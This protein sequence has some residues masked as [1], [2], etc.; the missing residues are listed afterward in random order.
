MTLRAFIL[1]LSLCGLSPAAL[2]QPASEEL[3]VGFLPAE[4]VNATLRKTLSPQGRIEWITATGPVRVT[5]EAAKIGAAQGALA[6]LQRAPAVVPI[7]ILFATTERR[8]VQR[9]PVEP[10]VMERGFPVPNRHDPPRII[11]NAPGSFTVVPAQPRDFTTRNVGPGTVVNPSVSGFTTLTPEVRMSETV[12]AQAGPARRFTGSTV[13]GKPV[14]FIAQR[15]APDAAALHALAR[16]LGA[17]A[18]DE[19]AWTAAATGFLVTPTI[20][21]GALV[22]TVVP[23]IFLPA[24][25]PGEPARPVPLTACAA[26][27]MIAR[28]APANTGLL[29]RTDQEFYR[30]FLGMPP[31]AN[32]AFTALTV[33]ADVQ[34]VGAQR[35]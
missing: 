4:W 5:D 2:A 10:P 19:P 28:G 33:T 22:V 13:P 8:V 7:D 23:Q 29:P 15:L 9:V 11:Q 20:S 24:P 16:K 26:S 35:K 34:Y 1:A 18:E 3:P 17:I 6:E 14:Q 21:G 27:V 32:E 12:S 25:A 30:I 31:S